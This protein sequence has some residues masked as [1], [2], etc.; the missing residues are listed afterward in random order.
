MLFFIGL[1]LIFLFV[2]IVIGIR[3]SMKRLMRG[4]SWYKIDERDFIKC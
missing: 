2:V 4:R 1:N 3:D